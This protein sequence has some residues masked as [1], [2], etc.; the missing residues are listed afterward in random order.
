M[1]VLH[2][3]LLWFLFLPLEKCNH[4]RMSNGWVFNLHIGF[5]LGYN[6]APLCTPTQRR[7]SPRDY[8]VIVVCGRHRLL[9]IRKHFLLIGVVRID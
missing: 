2:L 6:L 4:A 3:L 5:S 1:G 7:Q 8:P 9:I